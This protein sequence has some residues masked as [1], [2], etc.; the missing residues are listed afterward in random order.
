MTCK[1][2]CLSFC[3]TSGSTSG[4]QENC[5]AKF[6]CAVRAICGFLS[7]PERHCE[8]M[9][10][11]VCGCNVWISLKIVKST[12]NPCG[13]NLCSSFCFSV[14]SGNRLQ[15]KQIAP[16][17]IRYS[18][19]VFSKKS[20][21]AHTDRA[22]HGFAVLCMFFT[23]KIMML[24]RATDSIHMESLCS[25][26]FEGNPQIARTT[27]WN[28]APHKLGCAPRPEVSQKLRYAVLSCLVLCNKRFS[29]PRMRLGSDRAEL[30]AQSDCAGS[31]AQSEPRRCRLRS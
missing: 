16:T 26:G 1:A 30:P 2:A 21:D 13:E 6:T 25:S 4:T 11:V 5:G 15:K 19:N 3:E 14:K 18:L 24:N 27:Y 12:A 23:G 31:S 20:T 22:P 28:F 17:R 9:W 7:K 10:S 8:F 29:V